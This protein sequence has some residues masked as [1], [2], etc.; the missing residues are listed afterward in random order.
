MT[1]Q[2][3][4][5]AAI[6]GRA[7]SDG[8]NEDGDAGTEAADVNGAS[9]ATSSSPTGE[10]VKLASKIQ[11]RELGFDSPISPPPQSNDSNAGQQ[12]DMDLEQSARTAQ[13]VDADTDDAISAFDRMEEQM[14]LMRKLKSAY[15]DAMK[16]AKELSHKLAQ[17]QADNAKFRQET[18]RLKQVNID[19][20]NQA[21]EEVAAAT[22]ENQRVLSEVQDQLSLSSQAN[23]TL[24]SQLVAAR[25][26]AAADVSSRDDTIAQ[27]DAEI[28]RLTERVS[29]LERE[30][31][32]AL[33]AADQRVAIKDDQIA[34]MQAA[35]TDTDAQLQGMH[36]A[37]AEKNSQIAAAHAAAS[38]KDDQ[39]AAL[40]AAAADSAARIVESGLPGN[41]SR[42]TPPSP[43]NSSR[44][45]STEN[46]GIFIGAVKV[47]AST[48]LLD[49][50]PI[51]MAPQ[52]NPSLHTLDPAAAAQPAG[53]RAGIGV[54]L[55]LV[56]VPESHPGRQEIIVKR[57][58]P[59]GAAE[60][61]NALL[62]NDVITSVNG[63][64][65]E[66]WSLERVVDALSGPE[67][68]SVLVGVRRT[69][70]SETTRV[71]IEIIRSL[72]DAQAAVGAAAPISDS[73]DEFDDEK[74]ML[75]SAMSDLRK[76]VSADIFSE[77]DPDGTPEMR[78]TPGRGAEEAHEDVEEEEEEEEE[79]SMDGDGV[80][81]ARSV[82]SE[83]SLDP[84]LWAG[85]DSE[86][87]NTDDDA[88]FDDG[89]GD[90]DD[91]TSGGWKA[92]LQKYTTQMDAADAA[93]EQTQ[94]PSLY[95][96]TLGAVTGAVR[97]MVGT[98]PLTTNEKGAVA[99][100][101]AAA[102]ATP[103]PAAAQQSKQ[104][105]EKR[106][107]GIDVVLDDG[108][109]PAVTSIAEG[110]PAHRSGLIRVG[111][112]ISRVGGRSTIG[113]TRE[114]I[115]RLI[116]GEHG[117]L[118]DLQIH[119]P[120]KADKGQKLFAVNNAA[121]PRGA[122]VCSP[123]S[124]TSDRSTS[125]MPSA[126]AISSPSMSHLDAGSV[127]GSAQSARSEQSDSGG[128]GISFSRN[129]RGI[130]IIK[131]LLPG[132]PA[133]NTG[134]LQ[135]R[136]AL[137][138]VN[139]VM[140]K[141]VSGDTLADLLLGPVNTTV[142]LRVLRKTHDPK[143]AGVQD[144]VEGEDV[145]ARTTVDVVVTRQR[146]APLSPTRSSQSGVGDDMSP[147]SIPQSPESPFVFVSD[148]HVWETVQRMFGVRFEKD[149]PSGLYRV[150]CKLLVASDGDDFS[151]LKG[152]SAI[153][154]VSLGD[155]LLSV[156]SSPLASLDQKDG[157][158]AAAMFRAVLERGDRMVA[159]DLS[160]RSSD[161][162]GGSAGGG[163]RLRSTAERPFGNAPSSSSAVA[164]PLSRGGGGARRYSVLLSKVDMRSQERKRAAARAVDC[165]TE[166]SGR[167]EYLC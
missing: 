113:M 61:T 16:E 160:A 35:A 121:V 128:L 109:Y 105:A 92:A 72:R 148:P 60:K 77:P 99:A 8:A 39:I 112:L 41:D 115:S 3:V 65:S 139:S 126:S 165:R 91:Q 22:A 88:D 6:R 58:L 10:E 102:A 155:V 108:N 162:G 146:L 90:F 93:P 75:A 15:S 7:E 120:I 71:Q 147:Q 13:A 151:S 144:A 2:V 152:G 18:E 78:N 80:Y 57:L 68:S 27:Q 28:H 38:A 138:A 14:S 106:G 84:S 95:A 97:G 158:A 142:K 157:G 87:S 21:R 161:L 32:A 56:T 163:G 36:A 59:G 82:V 79:D 104:V 47:A 137:V 117:T 66:G 110:G 125:S 37:V 94:T 81:R 31:A 114:E 17:A 86:A 43:G 85:R 67:G 49:P 129:R 130:F 42:A 24:E 116:L 107:I 64:V 154:N 30:L 164:P 63:V 150:M 83:V 136:D 54:M 167:V 149:A 159:I 1:R 48:D 34:A 73:E 45:S 122:A 25:E 133:F 118:V 134:M 131:S 103:G 12:P 119:R 145:G 19:Y 74:L 135:V 55:Q 9:Q 62:V 132:G 26:A 23:A 4:M 53:A 141:D 166:L 111:D 127:G 123:Q 46:L 143:L 51:A 52:T 100:A 76:A 156:N 29:D 50:P 20:Y 98:V 70:G 96:S 5:W 44:V 140:V 124:V 40:Q 101:V 69:Q 153:E 89:L 33:V 11:G